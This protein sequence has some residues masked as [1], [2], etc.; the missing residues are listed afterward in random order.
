MNDFM[1]MERDGVGSI[2]AIVATY[3]RLVE[4]PFL[5]VRVTGS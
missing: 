1:G 5:S 3:S 2:P 4:V